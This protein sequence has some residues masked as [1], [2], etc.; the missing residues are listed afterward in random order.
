MENNTIT[1]EPTEYF[2]WEDE[3]AG[4]L[5]NSLEMF[6]IPDS[7]G[8]NVIRGVVSFHP[9]VTESE[10]I[11]DKEGIGKVVNTDGGVL[12]AK[13]SFQ[14]TED[15]YDASWFHLVEDSDNSPTTGIKINIDGTKYYEKQSTFRFTDEI[16]SRDAKLSQLVLSSGFDNETHKEYELTPKFAQDTLN[17]ELTLLEYV[18]TMN[19]KAI[20]SDAKST[21][22]IKIPKK[23]V[24][25]HLIYEPD[26]ITI[27]YEE[28][29]LQNGIPLEF[30]LNQ[31]GEPDTK[32]TVI[33]T[34]EDGKTIKEYSVVIKRP[35]GTIKG[36]VQLGQNLRESTQASYGVTTK[37][38]ADVQLYTNGLIDWQQII[39]EELTLDEVDSQTIVASTKS[40]DE[41]NYEIYVIP[42][43]Y[44]LKLERLGFLIDVT[45][46]ITINKD[47]VINMNENGEPTILIEGDVDRSGMITLNDMVQIVNLNNTKQGDGIYQE[48]GDFGQK[49]FISLAD[50]VNVNN[51]MYNKINVKE[52]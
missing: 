19:I 47:D 5:N 35:Y 42:G 51:N 8:S 45:T 16:A 50:L 31:L 11:I 18:D 46:G 30:V 3:F 10:H 26:G 7:N 34:A 21:M 36:K 1:E 44:D 27:I 41:G 48:G 32:I 4:S 37:Y 43:T 29:D 12:L 13:M 40:D 14:M 24:D 15:V 33:V 22:K 2:K 39:S 20:Q 23:D 52:Y 25:G 49:G 28:K 17:Y 6:T 38:I 9:P